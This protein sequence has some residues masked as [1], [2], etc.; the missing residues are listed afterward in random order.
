MTEDMNIKGNRMT[1]EERLMQPALSVSGVGT[2]FSH[3]GSSKFELKDITFTLERGFILGLIGQNGAGKST[4]LRILLQ[5]IRRKTGKFSIAGYDVTKNAIAAKQAVGYVGEDLQ[6]LLNET[7]LVNGRVLGSFFPVFHEDLYLEYLK[8]LELSPE[9]KAGTLSKGETTRAQLALALSHEPELL[10]LDEPTGGLDPL[11]R[12][13]FL[14][15]LQEALM[16]EKMG[17]VF[18]TH[19]TEDLDKIAD[20]VMMLNKGEMLFYKSKEELWEE[21]LEENGEVIS[22]QKMMYR[23]SKGEKR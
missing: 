12:T 19:I 6:L 2:S 5:S 21:L 17:I 14:K 23:I 1:E 9:K 22:L 10:L 20:Y 18:S 11:I 8:R 7:L 16:D 13:E 3:F 4:L 15:I